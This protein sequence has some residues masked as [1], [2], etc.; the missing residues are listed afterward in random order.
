MKSKMNYYNKSIIARINLLQLIMPLLF[1]MVFFPMFAYDR[2]ARVSLGDIP[3][4]Q[5]GEKC[6][7]YIKTSSSRNELDYVTWRNDKDTI[8]VYADKCLSKF[9][10][11][12]E[13]I[14]LASLENPNVLFSYY[15]N[16]LMVMPFNLQ[17][18]DSVSSQYNATGTYCGKYAMKIFGKQSMKLIGMGKIVENQRDTIENIMLLVRENVA[19]VSFAFP[20]IQDQAPIIKKEK[21]Y[22]WVDASNYHVILSLENQDFF[23]GEKQV[24]QN[25]V[26]YKYQWD[27][28]VAGK[29]HTIEQ[30]ANPVRAFKYSLK[31]SGKKLRINYSGNDSYD[32]NVQ[33]C[34][35]AGILYQ[36]RSYSKEI[37]FPEGVLDIDLSH[38]RKG[39]YVS[40]IY[41][42]GQVYSKTFRL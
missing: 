13:G 6:I 2:I 24:S 40:H 39:F 5:K 20:R 10:R 11:T 16:E 42:N 26:F 22:F 30:S 15:P 27:I 12:K 19:N 28:P 41:I 38:L 35:I 7:W 17:L 33:I 23:A 34:D 37:I 29:K 3:L 36:S 18:N 25:T 31:V 32:I 21:S 14:S 1:L 9:I 4:I 8:Y